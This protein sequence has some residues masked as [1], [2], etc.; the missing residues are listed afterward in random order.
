MKKLIVALVALLSVSAV[1]AN[2]KSK[3]KTLAPLWVCSLGETHLKGIS[4]EILLTGIGG[5]I[6]GSDSAELSCVDAQ[7]NVVDHIPVSVRINEFGWRQGGAITWDMNMVSENLGIESLDHL[8]KEFTLGSST[9]GTLLIAGVRASGGFSVSNSASYA[10]LAGKVDFA[11]SESFGL[12]W[13]QW[14]GSV[15]TIQAR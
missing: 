6:Y 2:A 4:G 11:V 1:Q 7:G 10:G 5:A 9:G 8:Y 15:M 14:S 3:S 12:E 13:N